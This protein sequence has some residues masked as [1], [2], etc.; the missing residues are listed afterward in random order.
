[1]FAISFDMTISELERHYGT[2]YNRAYFEIKEVL[3]K[4]G[5]NWIQ[6]LSHSRRK[7]RRPLQGHQCSIPDRLVQ[8]IRTGYQRL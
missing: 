1:M 8:K 3:R 4:N 6:H 5:F 7:F 2:P